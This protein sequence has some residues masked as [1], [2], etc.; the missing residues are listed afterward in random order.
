MPADLLPALR[1]A[2]RLVSLGTGV[3]LLLPFV[4]PQATLASWVPTCA[5]QL[6]GKACPLCGMTTAFYWLSAGDL[7]SALAANRFSVGLYACLVTNLVVL[8]AVSCFKRKAS[9]AA[10]H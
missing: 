6:E 9:H 3:V 7:P 8:L 5:W 2:W 10:T 4:L 1:L